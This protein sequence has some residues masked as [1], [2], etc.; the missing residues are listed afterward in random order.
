MERPATA[1]VN[2]YKDFRFQNPGIYRIAF[3]EQKSQ[4]LIANIA[5][6][7]EIPTGPALDLTSFNPPVSFVVHYFRSIEKQTVVCVVNLCIQ[8]FLCRNRINIPLPGICEK[9][10]NYFSVRGI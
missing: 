3:V 8:E 4:L 7:E 2:K 6:A 1:S 9:E 10:R 5:L